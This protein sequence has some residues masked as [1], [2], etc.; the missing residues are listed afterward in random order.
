MVPTYTAPV[1]DGV[2]PAI[3]TNINS[4]PLSLYNSN[5]SVDPYVAT[6]PA[7]V[8]PFDSSP[9]YNVVAGTCGAESAPDGG[10]VDGQ[11]VNLTPGA[12]ATPSIPLVPVQIFVNYAGS[13]VS[14][15]SLTASASNATGTGADTNCPTTGTGV[16]PTLQL[17]STTA[18]WTDF[19]RGQARGHGHRRHKGPQ[20]AILLSTCSSNCATTTTVTSSV[21]PSTAGQSITLT[22]TIV[23]PPTCTPGTPSAGTVTFKNGSTSLGTA[24]PNSSG[25]ATLATAAIPVGSN[26][27]TAAYAGSSPH[28]AASTSS[29]YSQVVNAA[30]TTTVVTASPNPNTYGTSAT[31]TATVGCTASGCGTPTGTATFTNGGTNIS[32]CVTVTVSSGVAHCTLSGLNGGSYSVAAVFT[33]TTNYATST[34]NTVTQ[35]VTAASTTTGLTSGTNPSVFGQSVTLTATVTPASGA[36][37]VG[38]VAFKDGATTLGSATLNGSGVA[39]YPTSALALGSNSLSA[40]FTATNASQLRVVNVEHPHA[41]GELG[42]HNHNPDGEPQPQRLW[43]IGDPDRHGGLHHVRNAG[44]NGHVHQWRHQHLRLCHRHRVLGRCL[45]HFVGAQRWKLQRGRRLHP[46]K[47]IPDLYLQHGYPAG[48]RRQHQYRPDVERD[49]GHLWLIVDADRH[50]DPGLRGPRHGNRRLQGRIDLARFC[51]PQRFGRRHLYRRRHWRSD[52]IRS[53]P[54]SRQPMRPTSDRRR[55]RSPRA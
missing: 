48:H 13:L 2:H 21:N 22:A 35:Q 10:T 18:T 37:A 12:T 49:S 1:T 31:L 8:F 46:F 15:A 30:P 45:L 9:G 42:I 36:P 7:Q 27:I 6:S 26:S 4:V 20:N 43:N 53:A 54:S 47:R 24:T 33:P 25:V 52:Q 38:T 28:W 51:R 32:A 16:M 55:E 44:R 50:G 14:A 39:T 5:L 11:P 23:C 19:Y 29:T 40:V 34:S 17:G 41:D 3:P